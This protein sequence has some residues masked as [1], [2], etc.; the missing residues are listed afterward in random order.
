MGSFSMP[1]ERRRRKGVQTRAIAC[2]NRRV[3]V[4]DPLLDSE[5]TSRMRVKDGYYVKRMACPW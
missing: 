2:V 4:K 3:N 1:G 5:V